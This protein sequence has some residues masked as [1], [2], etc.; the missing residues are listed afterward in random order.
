MHATAFLERGIGIAVKIAD[1]DAGRRA[2]KPAVV[3]VLDA[4]ALLSPGDR[5]AL[6]PREEQVIRSY[7]GIPAGEIAPAVELTRVSR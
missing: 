7:A 1:G 2:I 4:L 5:E 3:G 6:L